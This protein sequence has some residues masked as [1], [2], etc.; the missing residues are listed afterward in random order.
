MQTTGTFRLEQLVDTDVLQEIQDK[1]AE[2]TGLSAVIVDAKGE[3]LTTPSNF[4]S[5][6]DYMR[7]FPAGLSRCIAC[8]NSGGH[9]ALALQKPVVYLCHSGLTDLAAPIIVQGEY[10]GAFLAGQVVLAQ[11]DYD[12][13][14]GMLSLTADLELARDELEAHFAAVE[15]VPANRIKAAADL[16]YIMS[17]YIVEIGAANIMQKRL[18]VE[19][20][21]KADLENL[22]RAAELKALQ[23]QVNPHF[24]FNTLNTIARLA[25]LEGAQKTQGVVY[26]LADILRSN[27]RDLDRL[28]QLK[29]EMKTIEDYLHIQN[30]RFSDRI[31]THIE[32]DPALLDAMIPAL[33]LQPLVENA[34]IHGLEGSSSGGD[35]YLKA[36]LADNQQDLKIEVIDTGVGVTPERIQEIFQEKKRKTSKGHTTGIGLL[37]VHKRIQHFYGKQYGLTMQSTPGEGTTV[38]IHLPYQHD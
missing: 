23:S 35:I 2:A 29:E 38:C 20:Q 24:L 22:L 1:F 9:R 5:F 17:N 6:C 26:A 11:D 32:M 18:S 27:L 28:R 33:I 31:R 7:S 8:D 3:P 4:T 37:N 25:L 21:A 15:V 16:I 13:K 14:Q 30:V 10:I 12:A 19:A 34:I 36:G